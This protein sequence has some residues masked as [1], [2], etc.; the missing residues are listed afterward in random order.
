MPATSKSQSKFLYKKPAALTHGIYSA[1]AVLPG[2]DQ[3]AFDKLH[4]DLIAEWLPNGV[5]EDIRIA[6][7]AR[8][9]WR[10]QNLGTL[11]FAA[12]AR[13]R[14]TNILNEMVAAKFPEQAPFATHPDSKKMVAAAKAQLRAEF[15]DACE[16]VE[17]GEAASFEGLNKL[18][19]LEERI[20]GL[21]DRLVNQLLK[22]RVYKSL[23]PQT[24]SNSPQLIAA[25]S[26]LSVADGDLKEIDHADA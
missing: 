9:T 23:P 2:E 13:S 18:L 3:A 14:Y 22:A 20:C 5:F 26:S 8:H 10:L 21:I 7:L 1:T 6:D 16:V 17:M 4:R 12:V 24:T 19:D 11:Q 25:P 15:G